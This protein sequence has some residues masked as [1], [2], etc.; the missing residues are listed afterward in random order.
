LQSKS[1]EEPALSEPKGALQGARVGAD[2]STPFGWL[3]AGFRGPVAFGA[4]RLR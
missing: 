3:R 4:G 2:W 1:L